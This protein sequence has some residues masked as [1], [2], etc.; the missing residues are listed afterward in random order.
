MGSAAAVA[1][2]DLNKL[3]S[4]RRLSTCPS[5]NPLHSPTLTRPLVNRCASL[6]APLQPPQSST[7]P[8]FFPPS[9]SPSPPSWSGRLSPVLSEGWALRCRAP[10][11]TA[12][13]LPSPVPLPSLV[14]LVF[15]AQPSPPR[16]P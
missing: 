1:T 7:A 11:L 3:Q 9:L 2:D 8:P 13:P 5:S 14:F 6:P 4:A 10:L 12:R 15:R 16:P